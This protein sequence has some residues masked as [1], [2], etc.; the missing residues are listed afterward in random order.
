[1]DDVPG[2][3]EGHEQHDETVDVRGMAEEIEPERPEQRR[4]DPLQSSA[5]PVSSEYRLAISRNTSATP[6]VTINRVQVGTAQREK[7]GREAQGRRSKAR[8]DER[9]HGPLI[10]ACLASK[11]AA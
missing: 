4:M 3:D 2:N 6:S 1:M 9:E 5:P 10:S 8:D 11:P 7:A